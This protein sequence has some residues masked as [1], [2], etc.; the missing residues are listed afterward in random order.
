MPKCKVWLQVVVAA[1]GPP[2]PKRPASPASTWRSKTAVLEPELQIEKQTRA[3]NLQHGWQ[4]QTL[5][6]DRAMQQYEQAEKQWP[7]SPSRQG[8]MRVALSPPRHAASP[9]V[10]AWGIPASRPETARV[11]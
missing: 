4:Q 1:S 2:S 11:A 5:D 6:K 9:S 8:H 3:Q 10:A 7:Y